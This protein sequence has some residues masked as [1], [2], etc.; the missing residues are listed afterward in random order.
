MKIILRGSVPYLTR[1]KLF[2]DNSLLYLM[3]NLPFSCNYRC[4]KCCNLDETKQ[5][6]SS[7][8]R[9]T[10][11]EL[12]RMFEESQHIGIKVLVLAGEGEP[13][14]DKDFKEIISLASKNNLIPYIFTNGTILSESNIEFLAEHRASLIINLDSL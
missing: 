6:K 10:L 9:L 1:L 4:L 3:L 5:A 8:G 7:N 11:S 13:L 12:E 2:D 14:I